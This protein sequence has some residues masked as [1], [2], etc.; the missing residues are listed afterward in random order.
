LPIAS[1]EEHVLSTNILQ[2]TM[3]DAMR[4]MRGGD[5][6]AA[7]VAIQQGLAE[8]RP[9]NRPAPERPDTSGRSLDG[10]F[11]V[12]T[13]SA[14]SMIQDRDD[15]HPESAVTQTLQ[16][17][18][19]TCA[20]GTR[21]YLVYAPGEYGLQPAPLILM[22]HGCTQSAADFARGTRM[23]QRAATEGYVVV[24]P[25][26]SRG[27]NSGGCWNWF[28]PGDQQRD[29]GEPAI[30]AGLVSEMTRRFGCDPRRRYV[31]G[32]SAGGAMAIALGRTC[33]D[34]FRAVGAHSGLA[35]GAA[36]DVQS[37]LSAMRNGAPQRFRNIEAAS[38][39]DFVP[40]IIFHGDQDRTVDVSNAMQVTE[41][42]AQAWASDPASG[43]DGRSYSS[44]TEGTAGGHRCT[45][46]RLRDL[47]G[48][49]RVES[50][51]VHGGGHAWFGGDAAGTFTDPMGPDATAEML[52]FFS[53]AD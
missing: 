44:T 32:L 11:H 29:K 4:L 31:A 47:A 12:A 1:F 50:W 48:K 25:T 53:N 6:S 17:G 26:Q 28:R 41:D 43:V 46:T 35:Y 19:F 39:P 10:E 20:D 49:I 2:Q 34:I 21:D 37:A 22:L 42:A 27:G 23:H 24:Y 45:T 3:C 18:T 13:E 8:P 9:D 16:A 30:L 51:I 36:H 14:E 40:T 15:S 38:K 33:P 7:T 5:L 52:R